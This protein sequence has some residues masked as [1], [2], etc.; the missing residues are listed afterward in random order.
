MEF[1]D[2][3]FIIDYFLLINN[4]LKCNQIFLYNSQRPARLRCWTEN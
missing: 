2:K 3:I 4:R 1:E